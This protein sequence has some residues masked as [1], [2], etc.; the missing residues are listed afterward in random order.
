MRQN[1]HPCSFGCP[2][3]VP[4]AR[5]AGLYSALDIRDLYVRS[6]LDE[7]E[8]STVKVIVIKGMMMAVVRTIHIKTIH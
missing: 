7:H 3:A 1:V 4:L 2:V 6:T 8:L 5:F